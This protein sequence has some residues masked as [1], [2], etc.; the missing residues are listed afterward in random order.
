MQKIKDNNYTKHI[1]DEYEHDF[2]SYNDFMSEI[3]NKQFI[4]AVSDPK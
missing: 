4:D 3:H 2:M 1:H